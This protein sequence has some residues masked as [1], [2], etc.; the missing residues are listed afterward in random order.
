MMKDIER[1]PMLLEPYFHEEI[2]KNYGID[3]KRKKVGTVKKVS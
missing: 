3:R 2:N 1:C